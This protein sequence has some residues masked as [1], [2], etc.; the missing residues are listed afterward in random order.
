[1]KIFKA[2]FLAAV[3]ILLQACDNLSEMEQTNIVQQKFPNAVI[4]RFGSGDNTSH[5]WITK[6]SLNSVYMID[7]TSEYRN[8][9][10]PVAVKILP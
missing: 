3:M 2:L 10:N 6:D 4:V 7:A 8:S 9:F 5:Y 1:M